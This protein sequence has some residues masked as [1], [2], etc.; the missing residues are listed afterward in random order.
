MESECIHI[1]IGFDENYLPPVFSLISSLI[2]NHPGGQIHIHA[3]T[4]G[5]S[6]KEKNQITRFIENAGNRIAFYTIDQ[7]LIRQFVLTN[8]WTSV[9]YYRLFFTM[10]IPKQ[11]SRLLYLDCDTI[12]INSLL[13]LYTIIMDGYPVAAVYDNYVKTQPLLNIVKEGEYFNSGVLL[14]DVE[15]WKKQKISEHA[16]NY[17][18]QHPENILFVDQCALN[19]VLRNNW[20]KLDYRF[21]LM[22]SFL[23]ETIGKKELYNLMKDNVVIHYTLQRPW[24]MLCKNRLR[25]LYFFYLKRSGSAK[26][27]WHGYSDFEVKK[28]PAWLMIRLKECYFDVPR[29]QKF[30]RFIHTK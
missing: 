4:D 19:V 18:K 9:V 10:V 28:I 22:Y 21:N 8:Q 5:I 14:I 23:P 7:S 20:K 27:R 16:C 30:W 3:I 6:D 12:V 17:L 15:M 1:A 11:I 26:L 24:Q 25:S 29:L 13:P 2:S